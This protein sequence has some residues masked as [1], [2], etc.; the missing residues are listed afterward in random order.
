MKI[1]L[2]TTW[3]GDS[4]LW[5]VDEEKSDWE[6]FQY[7]GSDFQRLEIEIQKAKIKMSCPRCYGITR[8]KKLCTYCEGRGYLELEVKK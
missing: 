1:V 6:E 7:D 5:S 2:R 8:D 4:C 3:C